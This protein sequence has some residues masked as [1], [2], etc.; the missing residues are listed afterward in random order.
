MLQLRKEE[1]LCLKLPSELSGDQED[2]L[3]AHLRPAPV[4]GKINF[5]ALFLRS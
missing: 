5:G 1:V 3:Q 4:Y 2:V